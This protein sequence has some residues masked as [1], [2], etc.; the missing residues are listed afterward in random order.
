MLSSKVAG[1]YASAQ[2][3]DILT[4]LGSFALSGTK[5]DQRL[6]LRFITL[7]T[8]RYNWT[9]NELC[10]GQREI[11][12]LWSVDERTVKREMA[13]LRGLG[14]L[15]VIRQGAR[16]RVTRYG[17][18]LTAILQATQDTW[19]NVG[20]D[21]AQRMTGTPEADNVVPLKAKGVV[22]MPDMTQ[23]TEWSLVQAILHREDPA[24]YA[25]WF[26]AL[27]QVGR[28]RGC[29]TLKA[30]SR[31]HSTYVQSNLHQKLLSVCQGV[32]DTIDAVVLTV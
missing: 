3:Y 19:A 27:Q 23:G 21:Y 24:L 17:M 12:Q 8:A 6:G 5:H 2:K 30:P 32:D 28:A 7:I 11:A 22:P 26:H 15:V 29:I 18:D 13:K 31:F 4:A 14:W 1:R 25:S 20:P 16:G 10:V 9:R